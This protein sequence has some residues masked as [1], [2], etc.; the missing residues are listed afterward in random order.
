MKW[1]YR[2]IYFGSEALNDE[3][4]YESQLHEGVHKLNAQGEDGWELVEFLGH[5][6]SKDVWKYHAVFKRPR[7]D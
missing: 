1:E 7:S 6:H 5:P 3:T 4:I 2:I